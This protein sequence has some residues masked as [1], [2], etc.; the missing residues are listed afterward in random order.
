MLLPAAVTGEKLT[1]AS[2][3]EVQLTYEMSAVTN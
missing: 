2:G 3:A 1:S